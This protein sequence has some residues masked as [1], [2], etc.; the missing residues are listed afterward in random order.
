M[1]IYDCFLFF[2]EVD[3]LEIRLKYLNDKVDYFLIVESNQSI[4]GNKREF[5][6]EEIKSK[7]A[8]YS[9]K[10]LYCKVDE[11]HTTYL[12]IENLLS[13]SSSQCDQ[14]ILNQFKLQ[15]HFNETKLHWVLDFYLKESIHRFLSE[16]A[17]DD[18]LI[19]YSDLDEI[20]S[21]KFIDNVK[22][23]LKDF[24]APK[25]FV[26]EQMEFQYFLNLLSPTI[27]YG[28]TA[29]LW[30]NMRKISINKLRIGSNILRMKIPGGGAHFTSCGGE[31]LLISK[32]ENWGHQEFNYHFLKRNA[33]KRALCGYDVFCR[34]LRRVNKI[35]II[36]KSELLD[37]KLKKILTEYPHLSISST[38]HFSFLDYFEL[39][40]IFFINLARK[41]Y[42]KLKIFI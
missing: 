31:S 37:S 34:T 35:L 1:K 36:E 9:D 8:K 40:T 39:L 3:L 27:W 33:I 26:A 19:F 16:V 6:F 11:F 10:I 24:D 42:F 41:I 28:T 29:G 25:F 32:I 18:D 15:K 22:S 21:K 20:P 4:K 7:F 14:F 12:S 17:K 13:K 5:K 23:Q 30:S 2:Q 38:L